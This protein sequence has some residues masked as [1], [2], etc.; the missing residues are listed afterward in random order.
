[1]MKMAMGIFV[2]MICVFQAY[3]AGSNL[4]G[5]SSQDPTILA[6]KV[7]DDFLARKHLL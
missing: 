4:S 1:M 3:A 2:P 7:I 6:E 5:I